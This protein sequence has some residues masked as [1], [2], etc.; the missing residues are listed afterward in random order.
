MIQYPIT[1][2]FYIR[3]IISSLLMISMSLSS[4]SATASEPPIGRLFTSQRERASL[5]QDRQAGSKSRSDSRTQSTDQVGDQVTL[6]GFVR[7]NNGKTTVWINQ[8]PQH[9]RENPQGITIVQSD[10]H[11]TVVSMQLPSGKNVNLK[12][13]QKFDATNGKVTDVYSDLAKPGS[14]ES[15]K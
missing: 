2:Q 7:K 6:D 14:K 8:V 3:V 5:D 4:L 10:H 12:A 13:G 15:T 1:N 9:G 11:S